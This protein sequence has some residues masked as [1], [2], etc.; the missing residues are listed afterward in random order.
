MILAFVVLVLPGGEL[1]STVSSFTPSLGFYRREAF[2]SV[3]QKVVS[4]STTPLSATIISKTYQQ[5]QDNIT[6]AVNRQLAELALICEKNTR[7]VTAAGHALD[8]LESLEYPD[9]VTYNSVRSRACG[10]AVRLAN[11]SIL[12]DDQSNGL[13]VQ[14]TAPKQ[15][16]TRCIVRYKLF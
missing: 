8:L 12:E 4:R 7:N 15:K 2:I 16:R 1:I 6:F 10:C 14:R 3:R 9:T 13:N 5:E 11:R